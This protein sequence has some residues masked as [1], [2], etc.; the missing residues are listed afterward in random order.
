MGKRKEALHE[1]ATARDRER[2]IAGLASLAVVPIVLGLLG[3]YT[4]EIQ[5]AFGSVALGAAWLLVLILLGFFAVR[6]NPTGRSLLALAV[7]NEELEDKAAELEERARQLQRAIDLLAFEAGYAASARAAILLHARSGIRSLDELKG[8]LADLAVPLAYQSEFLF[9]FGPSEGWNFAIY[10]YSEDRDVLL[11]VWRIRAENHPSP[12]GGMGREWNRGEGHVG[13]AFVDQKP[14]ITADCSQP[15]AAE[16]STL[17]PGKERPH[18]PA[19]VSF[20]SIPIGPILSEDRRPYGVIVGTSDRPGRFNRSTA[21]VLV[22][23]AGAIASLLITGGF[24][25]DDFLEPNSGSPTKQGTELGDGGRAE[26][27][28]SEAGGDIPIGERERS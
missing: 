17:P 4:A 22:Q 21:G 5:R 26:G 19:Y 15:E 27:G 1:L 16:F 20:A 9:E 7:E 11:P 14:I 24:N 6:F 23:I 13:K 12:R 10:L 2:Q 18:D 25:I 8:A 28:G 3:A